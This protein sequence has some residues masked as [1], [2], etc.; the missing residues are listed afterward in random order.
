MFYYDFLSTFSISSIVCFLTD[1]FRP[2][3]RVKEESR[4]E[5][6]KFYIQMIPAIEM[7][8]I[9]AMPTFYYFEEVM[10]EQERNEY[11]FIFNF[12][13]WLLLTDFIFYCNH[14][15]LHLKS[16]YYFHARHHE[17]NYTFGA[18]AI[19]AG[20]VDFLFANI[21]PSFLPIYWIS[22]NNE[23]IKFIIIFST[24]YTVV[25]SHGGYK[26]LRKA[27]LNHHIY[28]RVNYGLF[29]SDRIMDKID[30]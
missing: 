15:L 25:V 4:K 24:F 9:V 23:T 26:F 14:R 18:G 21:L 29:I 7:N 13:A 20:L 8:L 19:Y 17:Y 28:R 12:F 3:L 2:D 11:P 10:K 27:H 30:F 5:I 1:I 6:L 22:P 16:L